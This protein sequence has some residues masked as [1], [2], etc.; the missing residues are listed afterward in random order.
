MFCYATVIQFF[1]GL[2]ETGD[3]PNY[4]SLLSGSS[5]KMDLWSKS[6]IGI[7]PSAH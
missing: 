4:M 6:I 7:L 2:K 5:I 1:E 3:F